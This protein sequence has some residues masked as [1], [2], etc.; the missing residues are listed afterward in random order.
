M[1]KRTFRELAN[2]LPPG[3]VIASVRSKGSIDTMK[4][5]VPSVAELK[6]QRAEKE[7]HEQTDEYKECV[8]RNRM[9]SSECDCIRALGFAK[10]QKE[11]QNARKKDLTFL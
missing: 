8:E 3:T 6:R 10:W 2:S 4:G 5:G 9:S 11:L 1:A 7:K